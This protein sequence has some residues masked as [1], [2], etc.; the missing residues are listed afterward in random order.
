[1][2]ATRSPATTPC[3]FTMVA[4]RAEASSS[5]AKLSTTPPC[6]IEGWSARSTAWSATHCAML[7]LVPVAAD[8]GAAALLDGLVAVDVDVMDRA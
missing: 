6:L 4:A 7:A 1:M 2:T 5:A 8:P 3:S